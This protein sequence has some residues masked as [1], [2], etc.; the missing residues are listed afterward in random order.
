VEIVCPIMPHL[1]HPNSLV[2]S[3][4]GSIWLCA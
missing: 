2:H 3:W 4:H 1:G